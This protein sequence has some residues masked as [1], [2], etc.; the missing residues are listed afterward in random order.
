MNQAG[1]F[2]LGIAPRPRFIFADTRSLNVWPMF[3]KGLKEPNHFAR[4]TSVLM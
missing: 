2:S 3:A 4:Y 1:T